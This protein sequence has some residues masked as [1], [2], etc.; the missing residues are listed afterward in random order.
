MFTLL[1]LG[2]SLVALLAFAWFGMTYKLGSRTLFE[3]LH[4]IGQTKESQELADGARQAVRHVGSQ[5]KEEPAAKPPAVGR[6]AGAPLERLSS[7]E[8]RQLK[9]LLDKATH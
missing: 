2:V 8:Q 4:A 5:G 9:Y 7:S 6:D 1:K 3:H